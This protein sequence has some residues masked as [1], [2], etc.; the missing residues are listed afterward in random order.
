MQNQEILNNLQTAQNVRVN[1]L[2]RISELQLWE[3]FLQRKMV[4]DKSLMMT[5]AGVQAQIKSSTEY[6]TFL[7]EIIGEQI[8]EQ[9]EGASGSVL[10]KN[11][12]GEYK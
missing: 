7:D 10:L 4:K 6:I 1:T 3:R 2:N 9:I 12:K 8:E 11:S 5:V